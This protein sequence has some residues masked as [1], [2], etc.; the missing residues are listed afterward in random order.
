MSVERLIRGTKE[1]DA[2]MPDCVADWQACAK[3]EL[4]FVSHKMGRS[5]WHRA[6]R[7][8]VHDRN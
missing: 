6:F 4:V 2:F 5:L 8:D 3:S 7:D 1:W